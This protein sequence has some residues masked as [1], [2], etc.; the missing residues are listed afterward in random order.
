MK[1]SQRLILFLLRQVLLRVSG[2]KPVFVDI[3]PEDM[4][5]NPALIERAITPRTKALLLSISWQGL[6]DGENL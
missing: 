1:S 2:G 3:E 5:I 4:N 6:P